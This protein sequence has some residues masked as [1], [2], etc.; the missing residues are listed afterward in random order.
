MRPFSGEQ[1]EYMINGQKWVKMKMI[2]QIDEQALQILNDYRLYRLTDNID[3]VPA[4]LVK[5]NKEGYLGMIF[6]APKTL[7]DTT[8][9]V[10]IKTFVGETFTYSTDMDGYL[11]N[12]S[13]IAFRNELKLED[14]TLTLNK[15]DS[16]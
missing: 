15:P 11:F 4:M 1:D 9:E 16:K 3:F 7:S 5:V 8:L 14:Y 2:V 13:D 12:P 6:F 10:D